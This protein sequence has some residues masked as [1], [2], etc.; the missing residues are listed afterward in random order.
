MF[1]ASIFYRGAAAAGGVIAVEVDFADIRYAVQLWW[2]DFE[3]D[4][5]LVIADKLR[6]SSNSNLR[7][8]GQLSL[9]FSH[10]QT[11]LRQVTNCARRSWLISERGQSGIGGS[12]V[13]S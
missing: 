1:R 13:Q 5:V 7:Y 3:G 2:E 9:V 8:T 11:G 12:H 6:I 10:R 4:G